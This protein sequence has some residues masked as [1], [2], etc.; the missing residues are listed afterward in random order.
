MNLLWLLT[1]VLMIGIHEAATVK[2]LQTKNSTKVKIELFMESLC[3]DC[4]KT[5]INTVYPAYNRVKEITNIEFIPFG[6][7][8]EK[9]SS[10]GTW[11]FHC[12]HGPPECQG[13]ILENCILHYVTET[14]KQV[15]YIYCL[16]TNSPS[17][18]GYM[19]AQKLGLSSVWSNINKCTK[20][21]LGNKL[22]HRSAVRTMNL[23]PKHKWVPW[24]LIN[25][26]HGN[27]KLRKETKVVVQ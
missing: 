7:A 23:N 26:I 8:V 25:G 24:I 11:S 18:S 13:N 9:R 2:E 6:N 17:T 16:E 22:F 19:C 15:N 1:V 12:Q 27:G 14:S 4:I 10:N 20:S 5:L 21:P 3:P